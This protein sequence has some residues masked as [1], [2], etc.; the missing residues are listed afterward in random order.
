MQLEKGEKKELTTSQLIPVQLFK[1]IVAGD[2]YFLYARRRSLLL[3][4]L[5][6]NF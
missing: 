5:I 4:Y 2:E 6:L 3:C 1:G